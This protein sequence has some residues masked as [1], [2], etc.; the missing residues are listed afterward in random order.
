MALSFPNN[1]SALNTQQFIRIA[2][3]V[4]DVTKLD[5]YKTAIKEQIEAAVSKEPGVL[6]LYAVYEK[7]N[8][9]HVT[10]FEIYT[11]ED[12]YKSHLQSPHYQ[13][14]KSF[15]VDMITSREVIMVVPIT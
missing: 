8:P 9:T 13:K 6:N 3:I 2:K 1:T 10:I 14:Y 12:A 4:V 7:E 15:T 11:D 5:S